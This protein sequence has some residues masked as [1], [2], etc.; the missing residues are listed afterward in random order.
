[1][2]RTKDTRFDHIWDGTFLWF[3]AVFLGS[4]A[5]KL[6]TGRPDDQAA[7]AVMGWTLAAFAAILGLLALEDYARAVFGRRPWI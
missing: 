1:M 2:N 6:L 7:P 3:L 4:G 5:Y